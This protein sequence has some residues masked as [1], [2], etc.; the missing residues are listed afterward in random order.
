MFDFGFHSGLTPH[1]PSPPQGALEAQDVITEE[2]GLCTAP[3]QPLRVTLLVEEGDLVA[4][5]APVARLRSA[6]EVC[7]VAPMPAR[8]ARID[9]KQG[10]RLSE[11]VL[12]REP[13]GDVTGH[14]VT[15]AESDAGLRR[16]MLEA[17]VWLWLAR[18]PFG[19]MPDPAERP[20]AIFVM[21]TD[22]APFAP[23]PRV[24]LAG[25][26]EAFG[27]GL[28]ALTRL[29][30]G[31]VFVCQQPGPPLFDGGADKDQLR[32][33][34]TGPRHPQGAPGLRIHAL[35]PATIDTPVW[36]IHAEDVASL[37]TLIETGQLPMTRLVS[38]GGAALREAR[39]VRAIP[40]ADLRGLIHRIVAPGAHDILSGSPL[41]GH[42]A[43]W[44][45][46]R[47]RQVTVLPR[48]SA[49]KAPHWLVSALTRSAT[50]MPVIPNAALDQAFGSMLPAAGFVRALGSGDDDTAIKMGILSLLEEDVA[51]ADYALGGEAHLAVLLRAMLD[52]IR[53]EFAA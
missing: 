46:P 26:E 47:H 3:G 27:R 8:V 7:L 1:F 17:G 6:P 12:F 5:G 50:P 33:E 44:L 35:F 52:R 37:G 40:G 4:Q 51:L 11:I 53:T 13:D 9:L 38:V 10:H 2:A 48:Q 34:P 20:A 28:K 32:V 42:P 22:T 41:N 30:D 21:A 15:G 39:L 43:H 14:N 49:G 18:R 45:A 25:R 36:D 23:D 31:P 19:G 29:T 16:L 24:A